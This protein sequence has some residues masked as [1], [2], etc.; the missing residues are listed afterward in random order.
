[1]SKI[2]KAFNL[3]TPRLSEAE[4][5]ERMAIAVKVT[6]TLIRKP[7]WKNWITGVYVFGSTVKGKARRGSDI[8]LAIRTKQDFYFGTSFSFVTKK[9]NLSIEEAKIELNLNPRLKINPQIVAESWLDNP[10]KQKDPEF[11]RELL[12]IG[13]L[14]Y[15][16]PKR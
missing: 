6:Q 14:I 12:Q 7:E 15:G 16:Q 3:L 5:A 13:V 1:M 8:D 4:V 9:L 11:I 10:D 2:E